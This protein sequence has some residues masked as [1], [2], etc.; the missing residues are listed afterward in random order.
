MTNSKRLKWHDRCNGDWSRRRFLVNIY[1]NKD[2][3]ICLIS[4]IQFF[5]FNR[6]LAVEAALLESCS[7]EDLR[8]VCRGRTIPNSMRAKIWHRFLG[9]SSAKSGFE[10]FNEIF[11][12]ANQEVLRNDCRVLVESLDNDEE[13][14]VSIMSDLESLLTY[15]CKSHYVTYEPNNGL[16]EVLTPLISL[17]F[18]RNEMYSYFTAIIESFIPRWVYRTFKTWNVINFCILID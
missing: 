3:E 14:K 12:L 16:L 18:P 5:W 4:A 15:Y 2:S 6:I 1:N 11:D 7:L 13:D 17:N 10:K 9:L 8:L